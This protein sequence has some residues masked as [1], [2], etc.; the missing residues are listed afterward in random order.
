VTRFAFWFWE[1]DDGV[2]G[3]SVVRWQG[4]N[5]E[6]GCGMVSSADLPVSGRAVIA[7]GEEVFAI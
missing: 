5:S 3:V 1:A 7:G 4:G 6:M 2:L